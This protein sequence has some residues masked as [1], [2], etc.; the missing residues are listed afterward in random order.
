MED[1]E[2]TPPNPHEKNRPLDCPVGGFFC[3]EPTGAL[4]VKTGVVVLEAIES[5]NRELGTTAAVITHNAVIGEMA[6]RVI[7]PS[8]GLISK[9]HDNERK[10]QAA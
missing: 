9:V 10:L 1:A 2:V 3:G 4:D 5:A 8:G 7:R 6:D